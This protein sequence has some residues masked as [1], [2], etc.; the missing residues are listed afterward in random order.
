VR[1]EGEFE[2]VIGISFQRHHGGVNYKEFSP[3]VPFVISSGAFVLQD[4]I[5]YTLGGPFICH[6]LPFSVL[7]DNLRA[8]LEEAETRLICLSADIIISR[9]SG[10]IGRRR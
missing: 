4:P 1:R 10:M 5:M 6:S 9:G 2:C 7:T 3:H 8:L